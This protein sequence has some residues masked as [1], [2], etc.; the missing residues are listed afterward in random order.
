MFW[1]MQLQVSYNNNVQYTIYWRVLFFSFSDSPGCKRGFMGVEKMRILL[2]LDQV[3]SSR[4]HGLRQ[5]LTP[6][7]NF[8]CDGV[9]TKW[10]VAARWK[11]DDYL[12]PELQIWRKVRNTSYQKIH[13]T[14]LRA[15]TRSGN[16]IYEFDNF[17]SIPFLAGD[18]LGVFQPQYR[19]SR[20]RVR[21][22]NTNTPLNYYIIVDDSTVVFLFRT[23]DL[24]NSEQLQSAQYH[25]LVSVYIETH[26]TNMGESRC[27]SCEHVHIRCFV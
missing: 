25:P 10:V 9:I 12:N 17:P 18:I 23:I 7:M 11:G 2:G 15:G 14:I 24:E 21:S 4:S 26:P 27:T 20:L 3:N 19:L 16:G 13:G 5:Q 8:T 22:E 6:D 1:Y